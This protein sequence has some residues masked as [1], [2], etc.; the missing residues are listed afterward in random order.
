[1]Q[2][3]LRQLAVLL[4]CAMSAAFAQTPAKPE[5]KAQTQLQTLDAIV[6]MEDA[7]TRITALQQ[8]LKTNANNDKTVTAREALV[9]SYGQVAENHLNDNNIEKAVDA[10]QRAFKAL[11]K[12]VSEK[13]FKE[14]V[15][16]IP[17]AVAARGYLPEAIGLAKL[18]EIRFANDAE[19]LGALGEFYATFN[20]ASEAITALE[21]AAKLA[22]EDARLHRALGE[23]YRKALRLDEAIASYQLA[24]RFDAQDRRAF[25]DLADLYRSQGAYDDALKLYRRQLD[26]EPKH[27]PSLKG[28]ALVLT[29]QGKDDQAAAVLNQARDLAGSMNEITQDQLLQTQLAFY[30]LAQNKL[31][32]AQRAADAALS[33]E[34]RYSWAR[35]AAAEILLAQGKYFEAERHLI[36]AQ[37]LAGFPTLWFTLG[38]VYLIVEDFDGAAEQFAKAFRYSSKTQFTARLGGVRDVQGDDLRELL[39]PEHQ[40]ALFLAEAPTSDETFRIAESLVRVN[41]KLTEAEATQKNDQ[42]N[43]A[44]RGFVEAESSRRSYRALHMATKLAQAGRALPLAIKLA[45]QSLDLAEV[46]TEANGSLR[47]YPNYDRT[48]RFHV[49]RGRAYDARGWALFK[50]GRIKDSLI[51][52]SQA[53]VEYGTLPEGKRALWHLATTHEAAGAPAQALELYLAAYEPPAANSKLDIQRTVI[54]TIYRKVNTS[55]DGLEA[56]LGQPISAATLTDLT[57]TAMQAETIAKA[58]EAAP[59]APPVVASKPEPKAATPI[60]GLPFKREAE[61]LAVTLPKPVEP[62][63]V[64]LPA[65]EAAKETERL[66]LFGIPVNSKTTRTGNKVPMPAPTK[67]ATEIAAVIPQTEPPV[68]QKPVVQKPVVQKNDAAQVTA[69]PL[70]VRESVKESVK[71]EPKESPKETPKE[72]AVVTPPP[73]P[74][75]VVAVPVV[76]L[77]VIESPKEAVTAK[78]EEKPVEP[79]PE[80]KPEPKAPEPKAPEATITTTAQTITVTP[81]EP[82][83]PIESPKTDE[84]VETK[85]PTPIIETPAPVVVEPPKLVPV[86]LP[87]LTSPAFTGRLVMMTT[88]LPALPASVVSTELDEAPAPPPPASVIPK[89]ALAPVSAATQASTEPTVTV[90]YDELPAKPSAAPT[91]E[92]GHNV[93]PPVSSRPRRVSTP[94]VKVA[95]ADTSPVTGTTRPRRVKVAPTK[96]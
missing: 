61:T 43:Q 26:I 19:R 33:V 86:Q 96:P 90:R 50:S 65:K 38:K 35:I 15:A 88:N 77:P 57:T 92:S 83:A 94:A 75:P 72:T 48:G 93:T 6:A 46:A 11:P 8:F 64:T 62:K 16:L 12:Q 37:K 36:E 73:Q 44:A 4:C 53:V 74:E 69:A 49:F 81:A 29:A 21:A 31:R 79:K 27:T 34:P 95:P 40:A 47:D 52:L 91:G 1:M 85:E 28:I 24:V 42:L 78:A 68:V 66:G 25:Y 51:A 56:K 45:D 41:A 59:V 3:F 39:A 58:N 9:A 20:A 84:K 82:I 14:T 32:E 13:F 55:L 89:P 67:P 23:A 7:N 22:P 30:Y 80:S 5:A 54:E 63:P 76:A 2:N 70:T 17:L 71:V 87:E 18:L 10:F 60:L